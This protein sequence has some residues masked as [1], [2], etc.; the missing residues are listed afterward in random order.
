MCNTD[1]ALQLKFSIEPFI[2]ILFPIANLC[3]KFVSSL[4]VEY[5]NSNHEEELYQT[6]SNCHT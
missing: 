6:I 2:S 4:M 1:I 5:L 3:A